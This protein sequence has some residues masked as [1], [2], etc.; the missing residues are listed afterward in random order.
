[1][2]LFVTDNGI[3]IPD[4]NTLLVYPFNEIWN[5]DQ[6]P[7]KDIA[8]AEFAYIEFLCS[9]TK[10]NPY[11]GY[12][13]SIKELKVRE[14]TQR[15]IP[16][17]TPD[18]LVLKAIEIYCEFRDDA[19]PTLRFYLANLEGAKKLQEYY[20][21]IDLNERTKNGMPVNKASDVARG[22]SQASQVMTN[23]EA[24]KTKVQQELFETNRIRAN[25]TVNH[26]ER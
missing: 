2:N 18:S 19:S 21:D 14:N 1:M 24:L 7:K 13:D 5:R 22:L 17:W 4:E 10:S 23:L 11:I 16:D 3:V 12:D 6:T 25:R 9:Y 15:S 8:S 20:K 26:F